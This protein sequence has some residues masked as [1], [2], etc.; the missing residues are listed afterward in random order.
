MF[1]WAGNKSLPKIEWRNAIMARIRFTQWGCHLKAMVTVALA[2][3]ETA[4]TQ[5]GLE[6]RY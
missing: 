2:P 3:P 5:I 1:K 6:T 4:A